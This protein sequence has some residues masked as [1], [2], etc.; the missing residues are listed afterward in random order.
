M[1]CPKCGHEIDHI[2]SKCRRCGYMP[3]I[4]SH[5]PEEETATTG[6][7]MALIKIRNALRVFINR[8]AVFEHKSL[9]VV[10][11]LAV[12]ALILIAAAR[13]CVRG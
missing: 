6:L 8:V 7:E 4:V 11:I 10:L 9:V 13:S 12:A 3:L 1:R 5:T 2:T